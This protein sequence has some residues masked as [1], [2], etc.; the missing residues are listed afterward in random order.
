[1]NALPHL[2]IGASI[3]ASTQVAALAAEALHRLRRRA[4]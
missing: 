3:V 1:M 2:L 4:S